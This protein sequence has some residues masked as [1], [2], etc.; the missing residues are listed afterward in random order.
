ML[1]KIITRVCASGTE[2]SQWNMSHTFWIFYFFLIWW[3]PFYTTVA[4]EFVTNVFLWKPG[5]HH[6]FFSPYRHDL[7]WWKRNLVNKTSVTSLAPLGNT[8]FFLCV[9][10]FSCFHS[11]FG[12]LFSPH[13]HTQTT[14][15][16][17]MVNAIGESRCIL[18][19]FSSLEFGCRP[20]LIQDS[21]DDNDD[22]LLYLWNLTFGN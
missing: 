20:E 8:F 6:V 18:A 21:D 19:N 16:Q 10:V 22:D 1:L 14:R 9:E 11:I 5:S 4:Q 7:M 17:R 3:S 12:G 2:P 15:S 13:T